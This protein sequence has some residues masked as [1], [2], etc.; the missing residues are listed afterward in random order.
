AGFAAVVGDREA[1][2]FTAVA[3]GVARVGLGH[4]GR[5]D[6]GGRGR[7]AGLFLQGECTGADDG[8]VVEVDP[9]DRALDP[10]DGLERALLDQRVGHV[11]RAGDR[12]L[13]AVEPQRADAELPVR[14]E[15]AVPDHGVVGDRGQAH[16]GGREALPHLDAAAL[17]DAGIDDEVPADGVVV[18][19]VDRD[20]VG[21]L[22]Q[23][24][25]VVGDRV[26]GVGPDAG[27]SPGR[28]AIVTGVAD[29]AVGYGGVGNA[30]V[31]VDA[32]R[33]G[34]ADAH[35]AER[36]AGHRPVQ[37]GADLHVL[38]P[39]V[40]HGRVAH[41]PAD[42]VDLGAVVP[43][44]DV[45][46]DREVRQVHAGARVRRGVPV[47]AG[48]RTGDGRVPHARACDGHVVD[49]DVTGNVVRARRDPDRAAGPGRGD[50]G[51]EGVGRVGRAGR[52]GALADDGDR[53]GRLAEWRG[54]V[55]EIG[56]VDR[57]RGRGV[58]GVD[59]QLERRARR[60]GR[61]EQPVYLVVEVVRVAAA[62]RVNERVAAVVPAVRVRQG[63]VGLLGAVDVQRQR[64][65]I[66]RPVRAV[67]DAVP[68]VDGIGGHRRR[69]G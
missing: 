1:A 35:A 56:Q 25:G 43:D 4:A 18:A 28:D 48:G 21:E 45:A 61:G 10:L 38:D 29:V 62:R 7:A 58:L 9:A 66:S 19:A 32:V 46:E 13:A 55:F 30:A 27:V 44:L 17:R 11:D 22:L 16:R 34:V 54:D 42:A 68:E 47:E 51:V 36:Q 15:A 26:A 50:G 6:V 3:G 33:G 37:P 12:A 69:E 63:E 60:I 20:P 59:L 39:D 67:R 52:V 40:R 41:G 49:D 23:L 65:G 5:R 14:V 31:E 2:A 24:H 57:V 53:A 64:R 8:H